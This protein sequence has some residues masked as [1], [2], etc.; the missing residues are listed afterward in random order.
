MISFF[1]SFQHSSVSCLFLCHLLFLICHDLLFSQARL[2]ALGQLQQLPL[3]QGPLSALLLP[4]TPQVS[5]IAVFKLQTKISTFPS[6][7]CQYMFMCRT[8]KNEHT[9]SPLCFKKRTTQMRQQ[10][11]KAVKVCCTCIMKKKNQ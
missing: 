8:K 10:S 6:F 3:H 11:S 2:V 9:H 5:N 1:F 4:A 7:C